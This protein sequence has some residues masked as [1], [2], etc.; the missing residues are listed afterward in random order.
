MQK[1]NLKLI[2]LRLDMSQAAIGAAIGCKQSNVALMEQ[3]QVLM[4]ETAFKL[5]E[6]AAEAGL[7]L[8]LDQIYGLAPM[9]EATPSQEAEA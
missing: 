5:R 9:P 8:S 3:G 2:R 6:V 4:P 1:H 7:E